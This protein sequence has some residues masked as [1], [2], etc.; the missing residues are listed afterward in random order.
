[1]AYEA[2]NLWAFKGLLLPL[3]MQ[4]VLVLQLASK[5]V[6][7]LCEFRSRTNTNLY[8]ANRSIHG[9]H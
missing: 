8:S 5:A 4:K 2:L 3:Y 1:M 7:E 6:S 9:R